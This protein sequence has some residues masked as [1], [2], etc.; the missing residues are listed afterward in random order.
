M[1]WD[2]LFGDLEAQAESIELAERMGEVEERARIE[3]AQLRLFDRLWPALGSPVRLHLVSGTQVSGRLTRMGAHWL[4]VD[5]AGGRQALVPLGAVGAVAGLGRL[6]APPNTLGAVE[7]RLGLTHA[8][9]GIARDRSAVRLELLDGR[10]M[11]GTIDRVGAD[12]VELAEHAVGVA[13]RPG[14]VREVL[15]VAVSALAV[16]RRDGGPP[17]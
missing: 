3:S 16:I 2:S 9:R 8:L 1:R 5:E 13:R 10:T 15:L 14:E 11:D 12:F 7:S 17:Y 6:A 4:L